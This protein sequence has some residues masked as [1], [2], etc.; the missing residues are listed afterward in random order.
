MLVFHGASLYGKVD[1]VPGL[2]YVATK[3]FYVQFVPLIPLK[4]YVVPEGVD[5]RKGFT[6][7]PIALS[8]KS[9]LFAWL[10]T[11]LVLA[12]SILAT[13]AVVEAIEWLD[14]KGTWM[15]ALVLAMWA[16]IVFYVFRLSYRFG[17]AAP[18]RALALAEAAGISSDVVA[19]YFSP[20]DSTVTV[21]ELST[22][23]P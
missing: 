2:F 14:G 9:V 3:F 22:A 20:R 15:N 7:F 16:G 4:S 23:E 1:Q 18:E 21:D 17:H 12:G 13:I 11:G 10:R 8:G 19:S 5:L 6:G